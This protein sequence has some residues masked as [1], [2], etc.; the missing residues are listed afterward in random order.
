MLVVPVQKLREPPNL[1]VNLTADGQT[2]RSFSY[3][4]QNG[5]D[6]KDHK[7]EK[8]CPLYFRV[9]KKRILG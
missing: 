8:S 4:V 5:D 3:V 1:H 2:L 6:G 9:A 7:S